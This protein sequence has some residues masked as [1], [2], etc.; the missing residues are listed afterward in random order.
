MTCQFFLTVMIIVEYRCLLFIRWFHNHFLSTCFVRCIVLGAGETVAGTQSLHFQSRQFASEDSTYVNVWYCL[1]VVGLSTK[2]S[3]Y[4]EKGQ[5][6]PVGSR[7]SWAE[8]SSSRVRQV[9]KFQDRLKGKDRCCFSKRWTYKKARLWAS[10]SQLVWLYPRG[11][12]AVSGDVLDCPYLMGGVL[13]TS[14]G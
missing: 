7:D 11:A 14:S 2:Y 6:L 9:E 1:T 13:L 3:W 4:P 8:V 5:L 10:V 12:L